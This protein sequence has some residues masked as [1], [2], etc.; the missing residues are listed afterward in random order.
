MINFQIWET[1]AYI[2]QYAIHAL[3]MYGC[4]VTYKVFRNYEKNS[5]T[6]THIHRMSNTCIQCPACSMLGFWD[7]PYAEE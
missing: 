6:Y 7:Y 3:N 2:F 5:I 4:I 1:R